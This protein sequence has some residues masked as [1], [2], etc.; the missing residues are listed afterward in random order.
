MR[1]LRVL[2]LPCPMMVKEIKGS[3]NFNSTVELIRYSQ[4]AGFEW[5]WYVAIPSKYQDQ[6][7]PWDFPPRCKV[8]FYDFECKDYHSE[9]AHSHS[10]L[11]Q[12]FNRQYGTYPLDAV[13][14]ERTV[15]GVIWQRLL[16]PQ[17]EKKPI[18][19]TICEPEV[20]DV[21][22]I[23]Q[24]TD[25]MLRALSAATC[26]YVLL[27]E[28]QL[29]LARDRYQ[30]YL[31]GSLLRRMQQNARVLYLGSGFE[32]LKKLVAET[33]KVSE[34]TLHSGSWVVGRK[35]LDKVIDVMNLLYELGC[36]VKSIL[37]TPTTGSK[38]LTELQQRAGSGVE[39]RTAVVRK[40]YWETAV[41]SH[42]FLCASDEESEGIGYAEGAYLAGLGLFADRPWLQGFLPEGYP[43]KFK[44]VDEG[45]ALVRWL[46]ERRAEVDPWQERLRHHLEQT[47]S[48]RDQ[49]VKHAAVIAEGTEYWKGPTPASSIYQSMKQLVAELESPVTWQD[50]TARLGKEILVSPFG[51]R[52]LIR[53]S[54]PGVYDYYRLMLS[55]GWEDD[56]EEEYPVFWRKE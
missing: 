13:W 45:V 1:R 8:L 50:L 40:E 12:A 46:F 56:C 37:T 41:R 16:S 6:V 5:Y 51:S 55:F 28:D 39:F 48:I 9:I 54:A 29:R 26:K 43:Y 22:Q 19:V 17:R 4:V 11:V 30:K 47:F 3:S 15:A 18:S 36:P 34:F 32:P 35:R 44:S 2:A 27:G 49:V 33:E 14:T 24:E 10:D 25:E 20:E 53:S 42:L 23:S 21:A 7:E 38:L 52:K 31:S